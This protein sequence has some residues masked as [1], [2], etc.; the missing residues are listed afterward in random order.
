VRARHLDRTVH[1]PEG[2]RPGVAPD[3]VV[4][5]AD[6]RVMLSERIKDIE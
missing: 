6:V 5:D 1:L 3:G 2:P 4:D